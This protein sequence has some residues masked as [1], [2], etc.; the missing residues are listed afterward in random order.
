M[1]ESEAEE[2]EENT[3]ETD[4]ELIRDDIV[5]DIWEI[6]QA[7]NEAGQVPESAAEPEGELSEVEPGIQPVHGRPYENGR[8]HMD[9]SEL[10]PDIEDPTEGMGDDVEPEV[11]D[12]SEEI[13]DA[14][15]REAETGEEEAGEE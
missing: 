10:E 6:H 4:G 9:L 13:R 14:V 2:R 8:G 15:D 3:P 12:P 7:A 5:E 1:S 11:R